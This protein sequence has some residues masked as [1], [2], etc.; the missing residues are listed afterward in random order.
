MWQKHLSVL[1][2]VSAAQVS[3]VLRGNTE[4]SLHLYARV[5]ALIGERRDCAR[6]D[7]A[8]YK[9]EENLQV[10]PSQNNST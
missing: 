9:M 10:A 5:R 8:L 7:P 2:K 6:S 1:V 4:P 3:S